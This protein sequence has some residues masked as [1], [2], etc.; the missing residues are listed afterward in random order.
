MYTMSHDAKTEL[1]EIHRQLVFAMHSALRQRDMLETERNLR[2]L[3]N[4]LAKLL[5]AVEVRTDA[6]PPA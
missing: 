2:M 5:K 4:R 6:V 1:K 3:E